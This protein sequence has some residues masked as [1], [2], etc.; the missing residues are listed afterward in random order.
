MSTTLPYL[1]NN[2]NKSSGVVPDPIE[3]NHFNEFS[4]EK[5]IKK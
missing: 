3:L 5:I 4:K 2:G 1:S